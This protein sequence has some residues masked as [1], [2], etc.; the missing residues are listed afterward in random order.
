MPPAARRGSGRRPATGAPVLLLL[1]VATLT[2]CGPRTSSAA[3]GLGRFPVAAPPPHPTPVSASPGHPQLVAMGDDVAVSLPGATLLVQA[4]GPE[5]TVVPPPPGAPLPNQAEGVIRVGMTVRGGAATLR[6]GDF[7]V[8]D[9]EGRLVTLRADP[10]APASGVAG[11]TL[12]LRL[13][14]T[15]SDG[16]ASLTWAPRGM[17][18][19]TW[20]FVIEID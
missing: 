7:V 12:S 6:P 13:S 2:A 4:A 5:V 19:V 20:D 16:G 11:T 8:H 18:L 1:A 10:P 15:F 3:A 14:G 17:P 9:E